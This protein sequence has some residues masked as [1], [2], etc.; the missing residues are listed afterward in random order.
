[1]AEKVKMQQGDTFTIAFAY[2]ENNVS[3]T[4]PSGYDI[5]AGFYDS[6]GKEIYVAKLSDGGIV[7]VPNTNDQF[8]MTVPHAAS[9]MMNGKV[10]M[11]LAIFDENKTFVDFASDNITFDFKT[12][13]MNNR[14]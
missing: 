5:A 11:E 6:S 14:V 12:R 3:A 2:K 8:S 1:M 13:K 9:M 10:T 4:F 7:A